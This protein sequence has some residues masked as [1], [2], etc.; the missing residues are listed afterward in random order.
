VRAALRG[1]GG[2]GVVV[3]GGD[4][5]AGNLGSALAAERWLRPFVRRHS[6]RKAAVAPIGSGSCCCGDGDGSGGSGHSHGS[7]GPSPGGEAA[8]AE[9]DSRY[10]KKESV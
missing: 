5:C 2:V 10:L 3:G 7:D 6:G 4:G 1:G 9:S 8:A